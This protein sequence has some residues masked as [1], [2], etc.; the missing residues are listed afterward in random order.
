MN[1]RPSDVKKGQ[2][3]HQYEATGPTSATVKYP[4][5]IRKQAEA[6]RVINEHFPFKCCA[7]CG[8]QLATCLTIAHLDQNASNNSPDNLARL[9][10]THHW[11]YDCGFY[12][13]EAIRLLQEHWQITRGEP[14]HKP[15]MKDAG[16][17][18]ALKRKQRAAARKA[19]AT[20]KL[21]AEGL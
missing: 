15:R 4:T 11:M 3:E 6:R 14:D 17:K 19:V 12:P 16:A 9:C 8:L 13:I 7:V 20:R 10:Q 5:L 1:V 18:A 2:V 21:R